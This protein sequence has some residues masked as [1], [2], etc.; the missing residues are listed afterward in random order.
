[1]AQSK[2]QQ[3]QNGDRDAKPFSCSS[4]FVSPSKTSVLFGKSKCFSTS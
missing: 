4:E 3:L 2:E 1:M